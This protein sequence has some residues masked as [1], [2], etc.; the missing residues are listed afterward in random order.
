MVDANM[1]QNVQMCRLKF[2]MFL[3]LRTRMLGSG[4]RAP[5]KPYPI[6]TPALRTSHASFWAFGR[7]WGPT[8]VLNV[9]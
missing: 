3:G 8:I 2:K 9:R 1:H 7:A 5:P 4:Y 6:F